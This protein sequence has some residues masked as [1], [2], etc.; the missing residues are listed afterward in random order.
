[1]P[2]VFHYFILLCLGLLPIIAPAQSIR[3]VFY[4]TEN[5]FDTIPNPMTD[6]DAFTPHGTY[7]WTEA[8]YQTKLHN[9]ATVIDSLGAAIVGLA[10]VENENVVRDLVITL[11]SDYNYIH[12]T[13]S[14]PRGID[15][16]LLY[17]GDRFIPREVRQI[18]SHSSREF[19]YVRGDLMGEEL[20]LIVCHLP[21]PYHSGLNRE[22]AAATL[23]AFIRSIQTQNPEA[24]IMVLGDFNSNPDQRVMRRVLHATDKLPTADG[25]L[26]APLNKYYR[27]GYG[28]YVYR[29][30]RNLFDN[31]LLSLS[32]I[33]HTGLCYRGR[34]GIY[35]RNWLLE[36]AGKRMAGYPRRT[37]I[38]TRYSGGF[39]D[40]L[41]VWVEIGYVHDQTE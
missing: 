38:G 25:T 24:K 4:N 19:L 11:K 33:D 17:Q 41:P 32:L 29:D 31:I 22:R 10:E 40:H 27:Q 9:I 21:A 7:R 13:T 16:A 8:R 6:D 2:S 18:D 1:M 12:R 26:Y 28:S 37:M 14:D 20:H 30:R 3:I 35:I 34:C 15:L 36:P 23:Y 39:S 5:L